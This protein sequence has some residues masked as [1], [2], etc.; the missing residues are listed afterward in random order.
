MHYFKLFLLLISLIF[1]ASCT[2]AEKTAVVVKTTQVVKQKQT[3]K[4]KPESKQVPIQKTLTLQ[5][6][7]EKIGAKIGDPIFIRIFKQEKKLELWVKTKQEYKLCKT[8]TI[9]AYSGE[10]GPKLK[11]GDKQSPE[12]FYTVSKAQLK[13]NSKYHL[14][15]NIGFPNQYD[16]YQNRTGSYLMIHGKCSSTGCYAIGNEQIEEI[17]EMAAATFD[18]TAQKFHVHIFPFRMTQKNIELHSNNI[19]HSFWV[20]LKLGHDIFER[21]N[22]VPII[23]A[24]KERYRF[25]MKKKQD[26]LTAII[27]LEDYI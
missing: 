24:S 16:K 17:Y 3:I 1:F 23:R 12:G 26:K 9:C 11:Q 25:F 2:T 15:I 14:A 8:Y 13:P 21:Y 10:L 5:K 27:K 7:L 6:S 18:N 20:N 22:V 4:Q 19:W